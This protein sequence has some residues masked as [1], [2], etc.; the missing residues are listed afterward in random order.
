MTPVLMCVGRVVNNAAL[1]DLP[2]L[3]RMLGGADLRVEIFHVISFLLMY[4]SCCGVTCPAQVCHQSHTRC[5]LSQ[6]DQQAQPSCSK[7]SC[8]LLV[9]DHHI[10]VALHL[11]VS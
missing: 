7:L 10:M 5:L 9:S 6:A 1:L 11:V 2:C 8:V 4:A 3:Q